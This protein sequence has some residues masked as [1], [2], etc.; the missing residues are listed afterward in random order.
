MPGRAEPLEFLVP[1]S[2]VTR[3]VA[4]TSPRARTLR[5][6]RMVPLGPGRDLALPTR[7]GEGAAGEVQAHS[8]QFMVALPSRMTSSPLTC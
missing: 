6:M 2:G 7:N 8:H 4:L 3:D 1:A 5:R